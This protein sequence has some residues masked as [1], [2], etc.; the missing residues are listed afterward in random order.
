MRVMGLKVLTGLMGFGGHHGFL[1]SLL[2]LRPRPVH[3]AAAVDAGQGL[4]VARVTAGD[5]DHTCVRQVRGV[6][7]PEPLRDVGVAQT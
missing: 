1:G 4:S 5:A 7:E 2:A 3:G 6:V